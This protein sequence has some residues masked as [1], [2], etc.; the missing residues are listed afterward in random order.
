MNGGKIVAKGRSLTTQ[1]QV[2]VQEKNLAALEAFC[3][4]RS[5]HD[6]LNYARDTGVDLEKL[7]EL[8]REI[9]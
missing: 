3:L 6:V 2:I 8:L 5:H 9:S 7:E 1:L 4:R